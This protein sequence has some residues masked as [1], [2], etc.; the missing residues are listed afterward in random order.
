LRTP[1]LG[2]D[3]IFTA[4]LEHEELEFLNQGPTPDAPQ[5]QKQKDDQTSFIGEYR[6]G[7]EERYFFSAS[8]RH[9]ENDLFDDATTWRLG[10][11]AALGDSGAVLHAS[12]GTG[13]TNPGFFELFGFIPGSFN[14]NPDLQPEESESFDIGVEQRFL[15]DRA[16]IDVT[17]FQADLQDEIVTLFDFSTFTTTVDNLEGKSNRK[18]VEVTLEARLTDALSLSGSYTYTRSRQ[19]DGSREVR[20]PKHQASAS[21]S[22][23]FDGGRGQVNLFVTYTGEQLD[24]EFSA[25]TP[26]SVVTLDDFVLVSL[27]GSYRLTPWL[28]AFGRVE[29]LLDEDY[30]QIFSFRSPGIGA[31]AG[32]RLSWGPGSR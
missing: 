5:N 10:A 7:I 1:E 11:R 26:E 21:A 18:G 12:Y 25:N 13:I 24:N 22:Y 31:Y 9:D 6:L 8:V 19:P 3:H 2:A 23:A 15:N 30:E 4:A 29:N 14:G 16:V 17:Y 32:L 28:E 20:R 27:T